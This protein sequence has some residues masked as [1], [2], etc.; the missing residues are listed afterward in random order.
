MDTNNLFTIYIQSVASKFS[1][2]ET[3]EMGY[4]TDFEILLKEIFESVRKL[5]RI[6][7]DARAKQGNKPDFVVLKGDIP[8]LYIEAKDI[9]VSLD[10][11]EKSEQMARYFGYSNLIL[12]DYLEF[13]FYRNGYGYGEP[14]KIADYDLKERT[15]KARSENYDLL[16]KTLID[17]AQSHKEPIKSGAH[18]AK[19]MGGKAQRIRDNVQQFLGVDSEQNKEL[20]QVYEAIKKML[21]HDLSLEAFS[22]MYAQTLVYGLFAARYYDASPDTFSRREAIELVPASNPFLR[23]F[24]DHVAGANFDKRLGYIVDELCEVFQHADTKKLVEEYMDDADPIIHF[25]ED[26]LKEY[27]PAL[28]KRMGAYY[29]PL[30]VVNFIIRSVDQILRKDFGL[31]QGLADT[32]KLA[33]GK[34]KVQILDPA[35]GT[36]TFI[37]A[38]V[39]QIYASLLKRKQDGSWPAY[40]HNDL[41]PRLHGFELM[42][43]PY[44]IAHLKLSLAFKQTGFWKFHRRLGIYL[45]NSLEQGVAQ[46]DLLSFG[47]AESIAEEAKEAS[48]IKNQTP[49]MVVIGNPPYSGESSN[50]F[51]AGHD[52]YKVEPR[53]GKLKERNS[54]WLNDDYVKFIRLAESTIEKTGEGVVGMIT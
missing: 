12:T 10:R 29:T 51:Y 43:A 5:S 35:V 42:M 7:H 2:T 32:S 21:V 47:L 44:T 26:F 9:G 11:V 23:H 54:K 38:A 3:S 22:D 27:D 50:A 8:I 4:R 39:D 33:N 17:F 28:R 16:A 34:H 52:V 49:I 53:G 25:Y 40:V 46:Q 37:S 18:L 15:I 30:Q 48:V 13:R 24:F 1:H 19:I 45:P 14:I 6:D 20:M 36:G 41:L 31:A